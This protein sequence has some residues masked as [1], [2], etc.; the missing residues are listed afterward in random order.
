PASMHCNGP[1]KTG[2]TFYVSPLSQDYVNANGIGAIEDGN[3]A[4]Y[5]TEVGDPTIVLKSTFSPVLAQSPA[6]ITGAEN[7]WYEASGVVEDHIYGNHFPSGG[8]GGADLAQGGGASAPGEASGNREGL[9]ARMSGSWDSRSGSVTD[10]VFG[11][12]DTGF[13]QSTFEV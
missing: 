8:G 5:I 11:S 3:V 2:D 7:I 13:N 6:L 9:W 1:C 10:S 4:W 12:V